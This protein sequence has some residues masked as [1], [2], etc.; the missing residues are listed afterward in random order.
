M[1]A[2]QHNAAA[3]AAAAPCRCRCAD[4]TREVLRPQLLLLYDN[5]GVPDYDEYVSAVSSIC[6]LPTAGA[7]S[8][9]NFAT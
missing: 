5:G 9:V 4:T 6:P 1:Y 3:A 8:S 7:C 2:K